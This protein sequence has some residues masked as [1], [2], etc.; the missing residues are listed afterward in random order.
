M[1]LLE[2]YKNNEND[3]Q[4]GLNDEHLN[5]IENLVAVVVALITTF[6]D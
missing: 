4:I 1:C 6:V 3:S 5:A 2:E